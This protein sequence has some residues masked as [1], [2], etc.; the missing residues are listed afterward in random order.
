MEITDKDNKIKELENENK[1]LKEQLNKYLMKNK[2][3]KI[4]E[5]YDYLTNM[6]FK[7]ITKQN[8]EKLEGKLKENKLEYKQ[9]E[10]ITNKSM[11]LNDLNELK[12]IL[13]K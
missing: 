3:V 9:I 1:L 11:W 12:I 10:G 8:L 5:S 7:Q 13:N 4:N 2:I 6:T